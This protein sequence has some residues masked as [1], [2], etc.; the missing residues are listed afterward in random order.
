MSVC[1]CITVCL[2]VC[3]YVVQC[4]CVTVLQCV[5]VSLLKSVGLDMAFLERKQAQPRWN[6][7]TGLREAATQLDAA[8][9]F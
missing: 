6:C 3:L 1:D 4:V 5:C 8:G 9:C 2:C 7:K